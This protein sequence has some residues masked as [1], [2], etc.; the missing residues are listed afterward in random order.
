MA[1]S[2]P[3]SRIMPQID[4]RNDKVDELSDLVAFQNHNIEILEA[5]INMLHQLVLGLA[6][7]SQSWVSHMNISTGSVRIV[8]KE[9][10]TM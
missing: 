7:I 3:S 4:A 10:E 1:L 5:D 9:E 8:A 2:H 6:R